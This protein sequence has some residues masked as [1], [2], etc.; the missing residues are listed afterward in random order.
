MQSE[1]LAITH[2]RLVATSTPLDREQVAVAHLLDGREEPLASRIV[3]GAAGS[4]DIAKRVRMKAVDQG[5]PLGVVS[6]TAPYSLRDLV[7]EPRLVV[8]DLKMAILV[9]LHQHRIAVVAGDWPALHDRRNVRHDSDVAENM[10]HLEMARKIARVL[11]EVVI[12]AA[13][14]HRDASDSRCSLRHDLRAR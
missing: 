14:A 3:I 1:L 5:N 10:H 2:L 13:L 7:L 4:A 9:E 8:Q 6:T 12:V 11:L